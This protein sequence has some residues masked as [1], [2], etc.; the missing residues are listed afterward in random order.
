MYFDI[1]K[2]LHDIR[3]YGNV[4]IYGTGNYA[5]I[6]SCILKKSDLW[7]KVSNFVVSEIQDKKMNE[8]EN[9]P[10]ITLEQ[11]EKINDNTVI[12]V[13]VSKQY[14]YKIKQKLCQKGM[15]ETCFF[16]ADY[17]QQENLKDWDDKRNFAELYKYIF[18]WCLCNRIDGIGDNV[19]NICESITFMPEKK[20][21]KKVDSLFIVFIV[22]IIT[23]RTCRIAIALKKIGYR[24]RI[25]MLSLGNDYVGAA[26]LERSN[27]KIIK[28]KA[29]EEML[30]Y[31]QLE[32][33]LI[34]YVDTPWNQIF[35]PRL[36][37]TYKE[38]F[39]KIVVAPY[40]IINLTQLGRTEE[41]YL[42]ERYALEN[43]DG[44]VWRYF[45]KEALREKLGFN[46]KGCSL[47]FL[48]YCAQYDL[49]LREKDNEILKLCCTP[50][51]VAPFLQK[52]D[53]NLG[54]AREATIWEIMDKIGRRK[55]CEFH[56]FFW[57]ADEK[58][59]EI[60]N[61]VRQQYSNFY[62]H[63]HIDHEALIRWIAE[64]DYGC[65]FSIEG[66][67]PE[68]PNTLGVGLEHYHSEGVYRYASQ[69]K[70]YDFLNAHLPIIATNPIN[71]CEILSEYGVVIN[72][73]LES[74]DIEFLKRNKDKF[75]MKSIKAHENLLIDRHIHKLVE[76][77]DEVYNENMV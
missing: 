60:L 41:D 46:Y 74:L 17:E 1:I 47:E 28:C 45:S 37:L 29:L 30:L 27:V 51:H 40:D 26:E 22:E 76:F 24:V 58:E 57:E 8:L 11:V 34:Y 54:F 39:G 48:D 63:I 53:S 19:A 42:A 18:Q 3:G 66:K 70:F 59:I 5:R 33:P 4:L 49:P 50:N 62:Y 43:A 69:N 55:D 35:I 72:M 21:L 6:I 13:A 9:I 68:W 44:V 38:Y 56:V 15:L 36:L 52:I 20:D 65:I 67:I 61:E 16:L 14:L 75:Y 73:C 7:E 71:L 23:A 12:L 31:T 25:Y 77:F 10:V 2:L 64:Y 32:N